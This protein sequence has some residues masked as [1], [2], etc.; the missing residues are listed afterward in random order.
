MVLF[1]NDQIHR[2]FIYYIYWMVL[3]Y[4]NSN[5]L[6]YF[7]LLHFKK[8]LKR[9]NI[10]SICIMIKIIETIALIRNPICKRYQ[11]V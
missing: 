8:L 1:I 9:I 11:E 6:D 5:I 4:I 3:F 2:S 7:Q 10:I